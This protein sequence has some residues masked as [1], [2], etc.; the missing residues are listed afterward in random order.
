MRPKKEDLNA[1]EQE[2]LLANPLVPQQ[3][4]GMCESVDPKNSLVENIRNELWQHLN[5]VFQNPY[6]GFSFLSVIFGGLFLFLH[7]AFPISFMLFW[8]GLVYVGYDSVVFLRAVFTA[9]LSKRLQMK[10]GLAP[11]SVHFKLENQL[12]ELLESLRSITGSIF[13][14]DWTKSSPDLKRSSDSFLAAVKVLTERIRKYAIVSL[15]TA[16]IIWRNNVYAILSMDSTPEDKVFAIASK[17]REAEALLIRFRWL[18]TIGEIHDLLQ[19]FIEAPN[20]KE[21][22]VSTSYGSSVLEKFHLTH[23]GP[24]AEPLAANFENV[25]LDLP[26]KG[27]SYW[28]QRLPPFPLEDDG[29]ISKFPQAQG[30]FESL[31]QVRLLKSH[32]ED[33]MVLNCVEKAV[34]NVAALEDGYPATLEAKELLRDSIFAQ[35]LDVPKFRLDS[36]KVQEEVDK[37]VAEARVALGTENGFDQE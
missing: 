30:L 5:T 11:Y 1:L 18:M 33:Q 32:L 35:Y 16:S 8:A 31:G 20:T 21:T 14:R 3:F 22:K 2:F 27:R 36:E 24:V 17:I 23:F 19:E 7:F 25:P 34:S 13:E 15:E 6:L 9:Y 29:L 12:E 37:L 28:L 4:S 10:I 26:F